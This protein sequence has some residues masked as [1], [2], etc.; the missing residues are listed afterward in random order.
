LGSAYKKAGSV[1]PYDKATV[2]RQKELEREALIA[3]VV[4]GNKRKVCEERGI[5]LDVFTKV[6]EEYRETNTFDGRFFHRMEMEN[7]AENDNV[8]RMKRAITEYYKNGER[9]RA[10]GM[11]KAD[12]QDVWQKHNV[13]KTSFYDA[14]KWERENP[15]R[16]WDG[17]RIRQRGKISLLTYAMESELLHWIAISQKHSGGVDHH[18]V[19]RV[20]FALMASDPEHHERVKKVTLQ[21]LCSLCFRL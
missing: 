19:C 5:P 1:T 20:A 18:A 2:E 8:K 15:G 21:T 13:P 6:W 14:I 11:T 12:A 10:Q 7:T 16:K 4:A 3:N 17:D 9:V